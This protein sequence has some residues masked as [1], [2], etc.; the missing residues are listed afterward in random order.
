MASIKQSVILGLATFTIFSS[1]ASIPE[2]DPTEFGPSKAAAQRNAFD[3]FNAIQSAMRQWG[4]SL[5][6]NGMSLFVVTIPP[7]NEARDSVL[8]LSQTS[9][10]QFGLSHTVQRVYFPFFPIGTSLPKPPVEREG[11]VVDW[12]GVVDLIVAR[13][14]DRLKYMA[15]RVESLAWMQG[16]VNGLLNTHIDYSEEDDG[17]QAALGRCTRYYTRV[18]VPDTQEDHLILA[19]IETVTHNICS[20]LLTVRKL[21]VENTHAD[22]DSIITAKES[23]RVL[24]G[25][26]KWTTWKECA[27]CNFD[28]VCFI[29]MWP[30]G[31]K[32]SYE[33]PNCRNATTLDKGWWDPASRYWHPMPSMMPPPD[34]SE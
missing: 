8:R 20:T 19:A 3:I 2:T 34:E 4:S 32:A 24:M 7:G 14:A 5:N 31:D 10:G 18:V 13:Y 27:G 22:E 17:Y 6:H 30:F 9:G 29:P 12:Q 11:R 16:E 23:L 25:K 26:L 21:V 33:K 28:E 15:D 1:A